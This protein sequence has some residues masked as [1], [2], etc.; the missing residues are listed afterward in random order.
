MAKSVY[1]KELARLKRAELRFVRRQ[2]MKEP[3]KLD[4][5]LQEKVPAKL[6]STLDAGF[7]KAF[8]LIFSKGT[9]LIEKSISAGKLIEE[10]E[11]DMAVLEE[12][13]K[14][15]D[16]RKF[17]R[18]AS[19]TGATHTLFSAVT[20]VALGLAGAWVP[21]IVLFLSLVLRSLYKIAMKYGYDYTSEDEKK[22]MLR[23][24]EASVM[25]GDE[26][27]E[28]NRKINRIIEEG[29]GAD[30]STLEERINA[31]AVALS[32]ALL[33]MKFLQNFP[34]VGVI[35]GASDYVYME[36]INDYALLKYQLKFLT[37]RNK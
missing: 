10:F 30:D 28:A 16:V 21:D 18:R 33:Y 14:R 29:P 23:I 1:D 13:G 3:T 7:A 32:H 4:L 36:K 15:R 2:Q 12:R 8:N 19:V 31:A 27:V 25:Q 22:F 17:K 37:D 6:E 11:S 34:I 24:I 20:G 26:I 5:M 9:A 35:G